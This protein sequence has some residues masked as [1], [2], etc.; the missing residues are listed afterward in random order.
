MFVLDP[1]LEPD[2]LHVT[3]MRLCTVRLMNDANYPW[4][5]LVPQRQGMADLIDLTPADRATLALEVDSV[6]SALKSLTGCHKLN[7]AALGNVVR[8][9]HVHVIARFEHDAAWPAPVW[10]KVA[11]RAYDNGLG[12]MLANDLAKAVAVRRA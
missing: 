12:E 10:G 9:L 11:A 4:A 3:D 2:T 7:V 1:Q 6:S 8:Q 5:I